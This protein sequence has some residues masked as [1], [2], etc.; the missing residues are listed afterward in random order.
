MQ[1]SIKCV[2]IMRHIEPTSDLPESEH[3]YPSFPLTT[4]YAFP[5]LPNIF[6]TSPTR[7]S[8]FS[9][10]AKCPPCVCSASNTTLP[11]DRAHL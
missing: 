7:I 6:L 4:L 8:G 9:Y 3:Q 5:P 1:I 10:A 11:S 2:I